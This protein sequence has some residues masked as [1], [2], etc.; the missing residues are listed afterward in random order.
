MSGSRA[1]GAAKV[2]VAQLVAGRVSPAFYGGTVLVGIVVPIALVLFRD[3]LGVPELVL[4]GAIGGTSL[5]GD[6][7][8]KYCIVKAGVYTPLVRSWRRSGLAGRL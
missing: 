3:V 5:V 2:S 1:G 6:F 4:L 7:Y 8:V